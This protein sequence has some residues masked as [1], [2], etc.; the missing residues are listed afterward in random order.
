M[1]ELTRIYSCGRSMTTEQLMDLVLEDDR[2]S[3][4]DIYFPELSQTGQCFH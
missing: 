1:G 4:I 3:I 2:F